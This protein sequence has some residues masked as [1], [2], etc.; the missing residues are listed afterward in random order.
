MICY[1]VVMAVAVAE[2]LDVG[3]VPSLLAG[4]DVND[5][6][7]DE[8]A[9]LVLDA[10]AVLNAAHALSAAALAEFDLGA[11]PGRRTAH[12]P[13]LAGPPPA[14]GH[15]LGR[16]EPAAGPERGCGCCQQRPRRPGRDGSAPPTWVP[17][18]PVLAATP[19][20]PLGTRPSSSTRPRHS[21][22]TPSGSWPASGR[23]APLR[24]TVPTRPASRRRSRPTSYTSPGRS[25]AATSSTA[26]SPL[27]PASSCTPPWKAKSTA[28]LR[29]ARD[30]D[31]A[32]PLVVSQ[33]R[34]E[35]L[36]DLL[37]Q[38]MRREPSDQSMPDRYRVAVVVAHDA[39]ELPVAACDSSAFR[40]VLGAAS[41]I[42]DIGRSTQI[43]PLG[44]RRAVTL[45]DG[46]CA[47]PGCE[48]PPSF[49]DIH[50][51]RPWNRGGSTSADNGAL[52]CRRHHTFIHT[53][54]WTVTIEARK[55]VIR[56]PDG[57]QH[58]ITRWKTRTRPAPEEPPPAAVPQC[59]S[60]QI[61]V[62]PHL[63]PPSEHTPSPASMTTSVSYH[64]AWL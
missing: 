63:G 25:T 53:H 35:A 18:P 62:T 48:R 32:I 54:G 46:G 51:C 30:G 34:A 9:R 21:T 4:V 12:S 29:A 57:Q 45:R 27:R 11:A 55:P 43:W 36:V 50:H 24:S 64:R 56:R 33:V 58:V 61:L 14:P 17:W 52:L 23:N 19:T 59:R 49:C 3:L 28:L 26:R 1:Y 10:E 15:R 44:I 39:K 2:A 47:F 31:L 38:T 41:E 20:S 42:L 6:H 7:D 16:C 5:L 37:T 22:L 13:R 60:Y 40:V 8:L